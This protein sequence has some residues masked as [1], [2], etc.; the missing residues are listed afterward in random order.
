MPI[1]FLNLNTLARVGNTLNHF[2]KINIF[3]EID[4][5]KGLPDQILINRNDIVYLQLVDYKNRTFFARYINN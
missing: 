5:G 1:H 4:L 3:V 2:I